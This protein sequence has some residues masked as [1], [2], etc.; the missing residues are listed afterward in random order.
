MERADGG[1]VLR[2]EGLDPAAEPLREALC[3]LGNGRFATRGAAPEARADGVHYPG[4]YAAGVFDRCA[5]DVAGRRVEHESIVNLPDWQSLTLRIDDG[6]WL[7]LAALTVLEHV[8]ELDLRRGVLTRRFLVEDAG[9]RRTRVAQRRL[10]SMADP[11]LAALEC[12]VVAENWSGRLTVRSGLD[13]R[14]TNR[15]VARYRDLCDRHLAVESG[16]HSDGLLELVVRTRQS[17]V[18]IALAA[19]HRVL[20]DG[21][22]SADGGVEHLPR[23]RTAMPAV[24]LRIAVTP[25]R[26]VTVEKVVALCTSHD[27][28]VSEP[29]EAAAEQVRRAPAFDALLARHVQ[30]WSHLWD[31]CDLGIEG[32]PRTSLVL[33]LHVFHLL[34]TVSRHSADLDVGIPAR[35]LHGEAYRGHVFW[36][37]VFVLPFLVL[38]LPSVARA[39]LMYH[40]WRRL[41]QAR[42]AARA[43]G[44]RGALYPWQSGSSGREESPVVHLNPRS[45]RWLPDNSALQRHIGLA[46]AYN[47]WRYHEATGDV[48]FLAEHGAEMIVEVAAFW[49]DLATY[50]RVDDRY[51]LCGVMGPDE[52]HDA[53]PGREQP[54]LDDNAYTNVMASWTLTRALEC[55]DALPPRRRREL[56]DR[57]GIGERDLEH[58]DHVSRRLRLCWH[59]DGVLS[60]FRGYDGLAELDWAAYRARYGDI[61]RLDRILEAE[62][63]SANRYQLSKQADVLMLFHLLTAE[64]FYAVLDRLGY[65]HDRDTI[66]KAVRY[67]TPRTCHGSTLSRVVHAWVLARSDRAAAWELF[68]EALES[69]IADVQGGTTGEGIHLG[70]MAGTVDLL[71]RGFTGL[72][73][74]D[75]ALGFD[76]QLPDALTGMRFRLQYRWHPELEVHITHATLTVGAGR[77][78]RGPLSVRVRDQEFRLDPVGALQVPLHRHP[79]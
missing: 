65:P 51:D 62:G 73:T 33:R 21:D 57:L 40:R 41:P 30:A 60:Q 64:E 7:D 13:G 76:P 2:Y 28:A 49:A 14:V 6:P 1:W 27:R 25:G 37:E 42:A 56:L 15:G 8:Q 45:G 5:D 79:G 68:L 35:G 20:A 48:A 9:G 47:A 29:A 17:R 54:G 10:V 32:P 11:F 18:R 44:Y 67:Y 31:R 74:H 46:V 50:D 38:R 3:A 71:Q 70:A 61:S 26:A 63:D 59:G 22:G 52:Y 34:Q 24:D 66:P 55:V 16:G 69:D 75:D 77:Q 4:T 36:D 53:L 19:R 43:A 39:M 12:T 78:E 23:A 72:Q 58:W